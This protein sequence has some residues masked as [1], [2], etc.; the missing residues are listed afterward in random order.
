MK[1]HSIEPLRAYR[2]PLRFITNINEMKISKL[3]ILWKKASDR[4]LFIINIRK[5]M[6]GYCQ[7]F[8]WLDAGHPS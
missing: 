3:E 4:A 5:G 7:V 6:Y 1:V 2:A 8:V